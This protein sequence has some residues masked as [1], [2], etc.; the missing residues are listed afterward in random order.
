MKRDFTYVDGVIG[1]AQV[2]ALE[3]KEKK[4]FKIT[5]E[6]LQSVKDIETFYAEES[7]E[8]C[9]ILFEYMQKSINMVHD[10][11]QTLINEE[12]NKRVKV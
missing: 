7:H 3:L 10:Y 1:N 11:T 6:Y 2:E 8:L 9:N 4:I 5:E 12:R